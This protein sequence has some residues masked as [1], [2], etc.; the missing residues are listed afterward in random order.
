MEA[1]VEHLKSSHEILRATLKRA[2]REP[3]GVGDQARKLAAIAEA[4]FQRE[5]KLVLPLLS[6]L[7]ELASGAGAGRMPEAPML[8]QALRQELGRMCQ[9]HRQI[10]DGLREL[11]RAAHAQGKSEYDGFIEEM[12]VHARTEE[13]MLYPAAIVAGDYAGL[14]SR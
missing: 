4:H 9:E 1:R 13:T 11:A 8:A 3:G 14:L 6:L 7:P 10:A 2:A 12:M 5:E